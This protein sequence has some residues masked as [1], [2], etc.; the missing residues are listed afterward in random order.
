MNPEYNINIG[1]I[2]LV[3]TTKQYNYSVGKYFKLNPDTLY[4]IL[5]K[6]RDISYE[7]YM[8]IT[9]DVISTN[10][11]SDKVVFNQEYPATVAMNTTSAHYIPSENIKIL[12]SNEI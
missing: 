2:I 1:D 10:I 4:T 8:Y 9:I 12:E 11:P 5:G 3:E 7:G 6:V